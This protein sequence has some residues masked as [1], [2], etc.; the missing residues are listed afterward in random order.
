[1]DFT[2][3][4]EVLPTLT[5]CQMKVIYDHMIGIQKQREAEKRKTLIDN[6]KKAFSTLCEAGIDV[7]IK[8]EEEDFY[9]D[10]NISIDDVD[11][12]T[13]S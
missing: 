1:M 4:L 3:I 12:F 11:K 9:D 7:S 10:D 13:F 8:Y 5:D 6:F 2:N